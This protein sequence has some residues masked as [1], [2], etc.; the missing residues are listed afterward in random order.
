METKKKQLLGIA[1][2]KTI[3]T[4]GFNE[5]DIFD[6]GKRPLIV[7]GDAIF[8]VATTS[9]DK[10]FIKKFRGNEA[11]VQYTSEYNTS[12]TC[13]KCFGKLENHDSF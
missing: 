4:V 9:I 6:K 5:T 11:A 12:Q 8:Q 13:P 10:Q 3:Q 2:Q 7:L 1:Y